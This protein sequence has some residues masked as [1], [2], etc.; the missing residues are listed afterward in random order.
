MLFPAELWERIAD[1]TVTSAIRRWKRPTVKPGGNLRSPGG[2]LAIDSVEVITDEDVT[3][4]LARRCGFDSATALLADLPPPSP[5]RR[6]YRIDFHVAGPD[7]RDALRAD[8][9][10]IEEVLT[11]L[12]R[13]D[14]RAPRPWTAETLDIVDRR[15]GVVSSELATELGRDRAELKRD[16]AKLKRLGLTVSLQRGYELSPRGT[17]VLHRL[18]E[19]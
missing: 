4:E 13:L 10:G 17:A 12:E 3:D 8:T 9:T 11:R 16:V 7:P 15:P 5:D 14:G 6:S 1:G 18:R 2:Y 19:V